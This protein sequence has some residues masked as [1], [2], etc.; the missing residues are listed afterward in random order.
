MR[1]GG[2]NTR[3]P[4]GARVPAGE[5]ARGTEV[6][7]MRDQ[8]IEAWPRLGGEDGRNGAI[9]AHTI[10]NPTKAENLHIVSLPLSPEQINTH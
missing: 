4:F 7:D 9:M 10:Q 3:Q 2:A 1:A 8:R 5:W 6:D